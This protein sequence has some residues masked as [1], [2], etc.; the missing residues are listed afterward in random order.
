ML[1][2]GEVISGHHGVQFVFDL[3]SY[4][5]FLVVLTC[6]LFIIVRSKESL[7]TFHGM[8]VPLRRFWGEERAAKESSVFT[9]VGAAM[10]VFQQRGRAAYIKNRQEDREFDSTKG[11]PGE[12]G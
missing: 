1:G 8:G 12:D 3:V 2:P 5:G 10:I 4:E 7:R 11:Y 6:L 9:V